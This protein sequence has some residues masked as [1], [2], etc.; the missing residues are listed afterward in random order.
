MGEMQAEQPLRGLA[1]LLLL[2]AVMKSAV[3]RGA[4]FEFP[5]S[6]SLESFAS[7]IVSSRYAPYW[8]LARARLPT[9]F[10]TSKCFSNRETNA[11]VAE[12]FA[13]NENLWD[14]AAEKIVSHLCKAASA[15]A[16][17]KMRV[18]MDYVEQISR[19]AVGPRQ[20]GAFINSCLA[21]QIL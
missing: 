16:A 8:R 5:P 7:H 3:G 17:I 21:T 11:T 1:V 10:D 9:E 6:T 13:K 2:R 14:T 4:C 15:H 20:T 19:W 12:V 18:L